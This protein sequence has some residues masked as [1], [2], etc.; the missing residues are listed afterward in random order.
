M[1]IGIVTIHHVTNYGAVFQAYA[2]SRALARSGAEVEIIDYRPSIAVKRYRQRL[3]SG[4]RPNVRRYLWHRSFEQFISRRLPLGPV[5]YHS[6]DD[7]L[8]NPPAYDMLV[9]GSDQIWC[10]GEGSFR[11]YDPTFFLTF[12]RDPDTIKI[13]YAASAGNTG[14]FC[15]HAAEIRRSLDEFAVLGVRDEPTA[16]LVQRT[17]GRPSTVVLDPVFLHDFHEIVGDVEPGNELVVFSSRPERFERIAM[18]I[19]RTH[20]LKIVSLLYPFAVADEHR[21]AAS[22]E[23]WLRQMRSA[24]VVLTDF[25]HG[26]AIAMRFGI[27]FL[28]DVPAGKVAKIHDLLRRAGLEES[29]MGSDGR[30]PAAFDRIIDDL[31][32]YADEVRN[33]VV[34][35][36]ERSHHFLER[37]V[38]RLPMEWDRESLG[39]HTYA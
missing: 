2:L 38:T 11:G 6:I 20:G 30:A 3:W 1:R 27:P 24:R 33:C 37:A 8:E 28:A 19:A 26:A 5:R 17:T 22:P 39:C 13:S 4:R 10:T 31:D 25:F 32:G 35:Q 12:C 23:E 14:D 7:L 21:G 16:E 9:A 36:V 15:D 18:E 34:D 29:L